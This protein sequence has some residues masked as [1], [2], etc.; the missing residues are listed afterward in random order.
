MPPTSTNGD[1]SCAYINLKHPLKYIFLMIEPSNSTYPGSTRPRAS[2][3]FLPY[4]LFIFLKDMMKYICGCRYPCPLTLYSCAN[5]LCSILWS[6]LKSLPNSRR[7]AESRLLSVQIPRTQKMY[8]ASRCSYK[9]IYLRPVGLN[10]SWHVKYHS[11]ISKW[12]W[13]VEKHTPKFA[14]SSQGFSPTFPF[15]FFS[16]VNPPVIKFKIK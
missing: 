13:S 8:K 9:S 14:P 11:S 7:K 6:S 3:F 4:I 12:I 15:P 10:I 2:I 16:Q 5:V 1:W